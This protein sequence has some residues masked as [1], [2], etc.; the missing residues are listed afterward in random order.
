MISGWPRSSVSSPARLTMPSS[1]SR[2]L[3]SS[4]IGS[5]SDRQRNLG[6]GGVDFDAVAGGGPLGF[7]P[8]GLADREQRDLELGVVGLARGD[9]LEPEAGRGERPRQP[10]GLVPLSRGLEQLV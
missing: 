5:S 7:A 9:L 2:N 1:L 6:R 8:Q 3:G 4:N 10:A